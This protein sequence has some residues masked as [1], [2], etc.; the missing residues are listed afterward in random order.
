M[1]CKT[2]ANLLPLHS[3]GELS[4]TANAQ[5]QAHLKACPA[6]NAEYRDLQRVT[7]LLQADAAAPQLPLPD[8]YAAFQQR[9]VTA[10]ARRSFLGRSNGRVSW[11][12]LLPRL[13]VGAAGLVIA[14]RTAW[15][16]F[17]PYNATERLLYSAINN[18]EQ[19][20]EAP[21]IVHTIS[22][23]SDTSH[24]ERLSYSNTW[25]QNGY[26]FTQTSRQVPVPSAP[27]AATPSTYY[28]PAYAC[29]TPGGVWFQWE[30]L[31]DNNKWVRMTWTPC[32]PAQPENNEAKALADEA[33][34]V[35]K[36]VLEG[37]EAGQI[38]ASYTEEQVA[39]ETILRMQFSKLKR[40]LPPGAGKLTDYYS[41]ESLTLWFDRNG[42]LQSSAAEHGAR[43][44]SPWGSHSTI[45]Y[46][47]PA[48]SFPTAWVNPPRLP[49]NKPVVAAYNL[50]A[51]TASLPA[52]RIVKPVWLDMTQPEKAEVEQAVWTFSQAWRH[53]DAAQLRSVVD[54]ERLL[55]ITRPDKRSGLTG[56]DVWQK[57]W[58]ERLRAQ[59]RWQSF[60]LK[61]D[62]AF[63]AAPRLLDGFRSAW[64]AGRLTVLCPA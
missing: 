10:P 25:W 16:K 46:Q 13:A 23:A 48:S 45:T 51:K 56:E 19:P 17:F 21:S 14:G 31:G 9:L 62:F 50:P 3:E 49:G 5:V 33:S 7:G 36:E 4:P 26:A 63:E 37:G 64:T 27:S 57:A 35:L 34:R 6:C 28:V 40:E 24:R 44:G 54:V 39:G 30:P 43:Y 41:P 20:N 38:E 58:Q 32:D 59:P 22:D 42:K 2:I 1:N 8:L 18:L 53:H 55:E 61:T 60:T 12:W 52:E 29:S 11:A 47:N 15:L